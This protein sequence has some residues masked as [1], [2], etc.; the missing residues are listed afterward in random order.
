VHIPPQSLPAFVSVCCAALLL[1]ALGLAVYRAQWAAL[2]AEPG[3]VHLVAGGA[4]CC[5][6][7]WLM[8][9]HFADGLRLHFLGLTT[10]SLLVGWSFSLL[11]GTA[12]LVGFYLLQGLDWSGF[13]V[14]AVLTV[15]V[16]ASASR[17]LAAALHRPELRHP[18][19]YFLGAGFAG[20]GLVVLLLGILALVLFALAGLDDRVDTMLQNWPLLFLM[21][22]SEGFINGMCVSALAVFY[23]HWMKTFDDRFYLDDE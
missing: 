9:I 1:G 3:R 8:N 10:L 12:A 20:G 17:A 23:P 2:R 21:M 6:L 13:A 11:A 4:L 7:L 16:P 19:I 5:L 22:F 18:F 15:L 14:S